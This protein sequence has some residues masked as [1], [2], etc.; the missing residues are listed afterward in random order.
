ML[1][2]LLLSCGS[3]SG[4]SPGPAPPPV[5]SYAGNQRPYA[6]GIKTMSEIGGMNEERVDKTFK[7]ALGSLQACLETGAQRL[8]FLGGSVAFFLKIGNSGRL[9]HAHLDR[10]TLGDRDTEKCMLLALASR[11]WPK[12]VGGEQGLARKSFDFDPPNDV[13]PPID[14]DPAQARPGLQEIDPQISGCKA[15]RRGSFE[16]TLYVA[17]DGSVLSAGVTPPD[18][19]GEAAVDCLVGALRSARFASPGSWPAKVTLSL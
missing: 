16:A 8:E 15:G 13:R 9:S 3:S 2:V 10:S 4:G 18:E 17:P 11:T 6:T 7:K 5:D 1:T 19:R 14:W 12:P